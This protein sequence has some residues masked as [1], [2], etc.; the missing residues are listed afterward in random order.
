MFAAVRPKL[1]YYELSV[2][3]SFRVGEC[4]VEEYAKLTEASIAA[5]LQTSIKPYRIIK[6]GFHASVA[7]KNLSARL[8][9]YISVGAIRFAKVGTMSMDYLSYVHKYLTNERF[10]LGIS[11]ATYTPLIISAPQHYIYN[12]GTKV[13][14]LISP[15]GKVF[16]M[17]SYTNF[18]NSEISMATLGTLDSLLSLPQGWK[19]RSRI[20]ERQI[21]VFATPPYFE[22]VVIFDDFQNFYVEVKQ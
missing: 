18:I 22:N 12:P 21:A 14:E 17:T 10:R 6:L 7:E 13:S 16:M 19:F 15:E 11:G 5:Q 20:L 4:S 2:F 1:F 8:D 9:P 3:S